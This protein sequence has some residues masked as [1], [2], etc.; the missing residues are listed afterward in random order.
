[1]KKEPAKGNANNHNPSG[2]FFDAGSNFNVVI[3]YWR[4]N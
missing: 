2:L 4:F 1:M 3:F